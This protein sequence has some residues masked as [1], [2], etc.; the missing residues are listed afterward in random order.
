MSNTI[1]GWSTRQL[2]LK[3]SRDNEQLFALNYENLCDNDY[4]NRL[5]TTE[6]AAEHEQSHL[7]AW[8][9]AGDLPEDLLIFGDE[10]QLAN[11]IML[12]RMLDDDACSPKSFDGP[13]E[14]IFRQIFVFERIGKLVIDKCQ[15][16]LEPKQPLKTVP[17]AGNEPP[18]FLSRAL[19]SAL[20]VVE[21]NIG[22]DLNLVTMN[23]LI[24]LLSQFF[25]YS[26]SANVAP[27]ARLS[28]SH[29][30]MLRCV[31]CN[32]VKHG[33][34]STE[35]DSVNPI[36]VVESLKLAITC[37][38]GLL[39][40]GLNTGSVGDTLLGMSQLLAVSLSA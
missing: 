4:L 3:F 33:I 6:G 5:F 40:V 23:S 15:G 17:S 18:A 24:S 28:P 26:V 39:I 21:K 14:T 27:A 7:D 25:Q 13:S 2:S 9:L 36:E 38:Y 12:H 37:A 29:L 10:S 20:R 32:G 30:H 11:D 1:S 8:A 22:H 16:L 31:L 35:G 34:S 19:S